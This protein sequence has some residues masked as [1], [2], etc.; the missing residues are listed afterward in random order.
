MAD[1]KNKKWDFICAKFSEKKFTRSF[2]RRFYCFDIKVQNG[3]CRQFIFLET[4]YQLILLIFFFYLIYWS[5][6][7]SG[8]AVGNLMALCD[9]T[10]KIRQ[11]KI[12][13]SNHFFLYLPFTFKKRYWRC[14]KTNRILI[15][16]RY[17]LLF[18]IFINNN[19]KWAL[20]MFKIFKYF[21][22]LC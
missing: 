21:Q 10:P 4:C 14:S 1:V 3:R 20:G 9:K 7:L 15:Q 19:S 11:I 13:L 12:K 17:R 18:S 16:E 8:K 5:S 2:W 22:M 6:F